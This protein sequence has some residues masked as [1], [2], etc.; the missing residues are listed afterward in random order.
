MGEE[1][2]QI[3][4]IFVVSAAFVVL[5]AILLVLFL[6]I[7]QKRIVH[8]EIQL[9]KLQNER[10][11]VLL[12]ATIEG[13]ERERERIAK[14]LHD[15]IGSLLSGLSLHLKFQKDKEANDSDKKEFLV[16]ACKL[17]DEGIHN[18]RNVSHNLL[19]STL[20]KFG[21]ISAIKECIQPIDKASPIS[22]SLEVPFESYPIPKNVSLGL[23]RVFQELIQ[24]TLKHSNG[25]EVIITL[26]YKP[27][28]ITMTYFDNGT[29]VDRSKLESN[30]IGIKSIQSRIHALEGSFSMS[31][32]N[33]FSVNIEVPNG[34][35]T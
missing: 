30:G 34:L 9:Q 33:G 31:I 12:K 26:E 11:Q 17:V 2:N 16:Q 23:L 22:I 3:V 1:D 28:I 29:E 18:V 24:N 8:Q 4:L 13:Q 35:N 6:V 14:D 32:D 27:K 10:Q 21:L 5:L 25:S 20:E 19:P 15:G 7:Y